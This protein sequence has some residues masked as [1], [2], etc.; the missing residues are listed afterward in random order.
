MKVV[1]Q[2]KGL[3][4]KHLLVTL[5]IFSIIG[6]LKAQILPI[7]VDPVPIL[8]LGQPSINA[9]ISNITPI[10][11]DEEVPEDFNPSF[12]PLYNADINMSIDYGLTPLVDIRELGFDIRLEGVWSG[13]LSPW[14]LQSCG[15][16]SSVNVSQDDGIE[17]L[18]QVTVSYPNGIQSGDACALSAVA[19]VALI[20][21]SSTGSTS[22]PSSSE[23]YDNS[24]NTAIASIEIT[25]AYFKHRA[26]KQ[27]VELNDDYYIEEFGINN[28]DIPP[29]DNDRSYDLNIAILDINPNSVVLDVY[30]RY[31]DIENASTIDFGR[32]WISYDND[33]F[34][35]PVLLFSPF[36]D[37]TLNTSGSFGLSALQINNA[38]INSQSLTYIYVGRIEYE[39]IDPTIDFTTN[40]YAAGGDFTDQFGSLTPNADGHNDM[41]EIENIIAPDKI[42][43]PTLQQNAKISVYPVP[44]KSYTFINTNFDLSDNLQIDVFDSS[45]KK[46]TQVAFNV[47]EPREVRLDI[48]ELEKGIYMIIINNN[49]NLSNLKILKQ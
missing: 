20:V 40:I 39:F 5:I 35:A 18:F 4:V 30:F 49:D 34:Y 28:C 13:S 16:G 38:S 10:S 26:V 27:Q 41:E 24:S 17:T 23:C 36:T 31:S 6:P 8:G 32:V 9:N 3:L 21:D 22:L 43:S 45:G 46:M 44:A 12:L 1:N 2:K 19:T 15:G 7:G 11:I 42:I 25:N 37:A 48:E 47:T 29:I 33:Y 14:D